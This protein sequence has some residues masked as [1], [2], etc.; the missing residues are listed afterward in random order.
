V[1]PQIARVSR[2]CAKVD[3]VWTWPFAVHDFGLPEGTETAPTCKNT[4]APSRTRTDTVRILSPLPLPIGLWGRRSS[5][6]I[7]NV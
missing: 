1:T 4:G 7:V 3:A 6:A 2:L 5:E